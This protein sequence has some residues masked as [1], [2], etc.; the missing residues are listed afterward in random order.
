MQAVILA[1]GE[2]TRLRPLTLNTPKAMVPV[3]NRPFLEHV[4]AYLRLHGVEQAILT[5][6]YLADRVKERF[7]DGAGYGTS[8]LYSV[9]TQPMGTAGAVKEVAPLLDGAFLVLNGDLF[10]DIDLTALAAFHRER[11]AAATIALV[12]VEDPTS[13]GMVNTDGQGRVLS[14][15]EK[16]RPEAV[17]SHYVNGGIYI[18]E[19]Q[20]LSLVPEGQRYM[21]ED[22]LFPRLLAEGWP[23]YGYPCDA[24]WLDM[25]TPQRYL[26]LHSDLLQGLGPRLAPGPADG[27]VAGCSIHSTATVQGPV[28]LGQGC[29]LGP[30]ANVLGP[31]VLGPGCHLARGSLVEGGVLWAGVQVGEKARLCR[32]L[33]GAGSRL[34]YGVVAESALIGDNVL[35]PGL[36]HLAPGTKLPGDALTPLPSRP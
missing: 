18:L 22:G 10:T 17:T 7:G 25:G 24:Y 31:V 5:L 8:L 11:G 3:L 2:G 32:C 13:F 9:E 19:P 16:P 28:L 30:G 14:F 33:V 27:G 15:V 23:V 1:G 34:G 4:L 12:R 26:Q 35:V 21:F 6:S 29:V 20:V 36:Q